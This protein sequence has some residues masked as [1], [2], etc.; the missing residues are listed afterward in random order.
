[1]IK[2]E[3]CPQCGSRHYK[4]NGRIHTGKQNHKCK[5]CGRAFVLVP[6]NHVI[7]EEQRAVIERLLLERISLREICRVIG[8]GL[9]W[10]LYFMV[11]R[12]TAAPD[13][14]YIQP[15]AGAQRVIPHRLEAEVDE[16]WSFVGKKANRQWVWIAMDADT[17]QILAFHVGDHSRQSARASWGKV[18]AGYQ[19]QA[20]FYT[21]CYEVYKGVIPSA[22]HRAITKLARKTNQVERFDCTLRQRV[23][24]LVRATLS[25]SRK[26]TN[27]SGAIKYFIC[28]YNLTKGAAFLGWHY[29]LERAARLL[30]EPAQDPRPVPEADSLRIQ[31][32]ATVNPAS[33][34]PARATASEPPSARVG[35]PAAFGPVVFLPGEIG[36][37]LRREVRG[38][39]VSLLIGQRAGI[40]GRHLGPDERR[41]QRKARHAGTNV[42]RLRAPQ[43]REHKPV[44]AGFEPLA[45]GT[46][47]GAAFGNVHRLAAR[48]V[49][50]ARSPD[51]AKAAA[52]DF[53]AGRHSLRE[54]GNISEQAGHL[55]AVGG[56][57]LAVHRAPKA[58]VNAVCQRLDAAAARTVFGKQPGKADQR[59]CVRGAAAVEVAVRALEGVADVGRCRRA[60]IGHYPLPVADRFTEGPVRNCR[61]GRRRQRH[62]GSCG[63]IRGERQA[64]REQ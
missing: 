61:R 12:F 9:R 33:A 1:M 43:G 50:R 26:L 48:S 34:Q 16:L 60:G 24:R 37:R 15:T 21:D 55:A 47:T 56:K 4:R 40:A 5:A 18:P 53:A 44:R 30:H 2:R 41:G 25:F 23:S 10:L 8:V 45:V 51:F 28:D 64:R 57:R 3:A 39:V 6:E 59:R 22:Q 58:L 32:S 17:R 11:E 13:D 35:G 62:G 29:P 42:K 7:T 49:H 20:M 31:S 46:V 63:V 36:P 54:P 38:D 52:L 27:H 19:E 14:L